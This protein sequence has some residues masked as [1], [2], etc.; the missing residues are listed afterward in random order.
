MAAKYEE[1]VKNYR[2]HRELAR[3]IPTIY[4]LFG[5][6]SVSWGKGFPNTRMAFRLRAVL[7]MAWEHGCHRLRKENTMK[8]RKIM[9]PVIAAVL[10]AAALLTLLPPVTVQAASSS[11]IRNQINE[12]K[13]QR[14]EIQDDIEDVQE[15]YQKNAD[16]IEDIVARKDVIDQ[17]INLLHAEIINI[18]SQISTYNVL[19]ADKQDEL[20]HAQERYD[21]LQEKNR[22][23]VRAMEEEGTLSYWE[24]LFQA[25]SFTDLL[26]RISMVEEI[27]AADQRH[28][29]E[30]SDAA[31]EV[32]T[33]QEELETEKTEVE[34]TKVEL[35]V[36]QTELDNKR[37][38]ADD[39]LQELVDKGIELSDLEERYAQQKEDILD[40]IAL[41]EKEYNEAKHAEWLAYMAT[42]VPPTTTAPPTSGG[43]DVG[44]GTSS[45]TS[46]PP[47]NTG[48]L[49]P[50]SYRLLTSPFGRRQSPT[51]GASSFHRGVDLGAPAGTPIVAS[52]TGIVTQAGSNG[53]LGICV[54]I[55]HGDGFSSV[56]GHMTNT[57]VS[58]G[59]A[60]SAGQVIGYVGSTGIST[61]NHLHF[62]IAYNGTYVNPA[63]YVPLY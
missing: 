15:Q 57:I 21:E 23:R 20:D 28:L 43:G 16:E 32:E 34:K 52:R 37:E 30:L 26:D 12:L 51:A 7:Q 13:K 46:T 31:D 24:V 63:Q 25:N 2:N 4:C 45:G 38:E 36:T 44:G 48:W 11:E 39:L 58:A 10:S 9:T 5:E 54:T 55:N 8:F 53:G 50:C 56:Y 3:Y 41:K 29:R 62:G 14:E 19:I 33:A 18:N 61:G 1:M 47:S 6:M 49:I 59:Q 40:D 17:E 22:L 42:Y 60:V 35:D 27:A